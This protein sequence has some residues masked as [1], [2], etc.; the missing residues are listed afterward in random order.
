MIFT[1][2][3]LSIYLAFYVH[4]V[5]KYISILFVCHIEKFQRIL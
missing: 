2:I 3:Y 4:Y 5:Y 1:G